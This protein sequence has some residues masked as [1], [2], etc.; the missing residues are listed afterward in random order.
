MTKDNDSNTFESQLESKVNDA[1]IVRKIVFIIVSSL[2]LILVIG[3]VSGYFYIKSALGP[4]D[5]ESTEEIEVEIPLGSSSTQI[6]NTLEENGLI[7][8][9]TIFRFYVKFRNYSNF[10]AGEY[11]LSPSLT[12]DE[13]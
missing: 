4:V 12:L 2:I 7:K 10:Q 6:A 9:S 3:V 5:Q 8:N 1:K 11:T 13:I